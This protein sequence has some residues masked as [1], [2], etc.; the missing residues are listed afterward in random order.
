M[1]HFPQTQLEDSDIW[2]FMARD[3]M[4]GFGWILCRNVAIRVQVIGVAL[5]YRNLVIYPYHTTQIQLLVITAPVIAQSLRC[6]TILTLTDI[7]V[8]LDSGA[9]R[10]RSWK[11]RD[12]QQSSSGCLHS[13]GPYQ[14]P[15]PTSQNCLPTQGQS[16]QWVELVRITATGDLDYSNW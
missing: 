16:G 9:G 1:L 4:E 6:V 2:N 11:F 13:S 12:S 5:C 14:A 3:L 15:S 8:I 10:W 7:Q